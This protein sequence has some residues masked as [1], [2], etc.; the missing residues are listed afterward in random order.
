MRDGLV[1]V[2]LCFTTGPFPL[3]SS[4]LSF[5]SLAHLTLRPL[6]HLPLLLWTAFALQSSSSTCLSSLL[7]AVGSRSKTGYYPAFPS[8][9]TGRTPS[10]NLIGFFLHSQGTTAHTTTGQ[11][12]FTLVSLFEDQHLFIVFSASLFPLPSSF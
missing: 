9:L 3:P 5:C 7:P 11:R 8:R 6:H 4:R 2:C 10:H 1:S 12:F